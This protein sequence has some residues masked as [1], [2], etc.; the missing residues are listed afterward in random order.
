MIFAGGMCR[1]V[2]VALGNARGW[3]F[4][5]A[6]FKLG[7][8]CSHGMSSSCGPPGKSWNYEVTADDARFL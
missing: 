7:E 1:E 6:A 8:H 2:L 4:H 5:R 3:T